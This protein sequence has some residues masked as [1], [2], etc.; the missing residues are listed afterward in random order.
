[1]YSLLSKEF[2][3]ARRWWLTPIILLRRQRSG[4]LRFKASLGK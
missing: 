2:N 3:Y 1:M 4:G